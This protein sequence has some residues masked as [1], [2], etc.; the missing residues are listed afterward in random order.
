MRKAKQSQLMLSQR[1]RDGRI[2][3]Q[4][5]ERCLEAAA[6]WQIMLLPRERGVPVARRHFVGGSV[7]DVL[8]PC[9]KMRPPSARKRRVHRRFFKLSKTFNRVSH[10]GYN[11]FEA[12]NNS[13]RAFARL[14]FDCL[15][16]R[17]A[18]KPCPLTLGV[19]A[20]LDFHQLHGVCQ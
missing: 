10:S 5:P 13:I 8:T 12:S 6:T 20:R 4:P 18:A 11:R 16:I 19:L 1:Q 9:L 2:L 14:K 15:H 7:S 17:Q 3:T